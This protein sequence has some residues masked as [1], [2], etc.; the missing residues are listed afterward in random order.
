MKLSY[1][2]AHYDYE[3]IAA[4]M[5]ESELTGHYRGRHFQFNYPR[6]IPVPQPIL[7][8]NYRGSTYR[9]TATGGTEA[10][11]PVEGLREVASTSTQSIKTSLRARQA[12]L[13]EVARVH[14]Q[15]IQR[16]LEHRIE[17]ARAKGDQQLINLLE[18]EM[19][20]IA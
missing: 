3:P 16:S 5:A 9:T 8:L 13:S 4:N 14:R 2:G 17:V 12:L 19:Q 10:L 6:H 7:T 18:R 11:V 20:Q 15:N 1:R